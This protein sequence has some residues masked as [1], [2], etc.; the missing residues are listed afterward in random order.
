MF[1]CET[2][3]AAK[4]R[5]CALE[6]N[7]VYRFLSSRY[8]LIAA[9]LLALGLTSFSLQGGWA[10]DDYIHKT[11]I[12]KTSPFADLLGT[13]DGLFDFFDGNPDRTTRLIEA[14]IYPWWTYSK[15]KVSFWRPISEWS[16]YLDY[17][18]WP[19]RPDLMHLQNLFWF[20]LLVCAVGVAY[21]RLTGAG[22]V[23]GLAVLLYAIDDA[24]GTPVGYLANRNVLLAAAFGVFCLVCHDRWVRD[25]RWHQGLLAL[26]LF[27]MSL[28]SAEAGVATCAYLLAYGFFLDPR[29]RWDRLRSLAPYGMVTVV[30]RVIW[31]QLDKGVSGAGLYIDLLADPLEYGLNLLS[32]A[33]V[34]LLGQWFVPPSDLGFTL[35]PGEFMLFVLGA[36]V[37]LGVLAIPI[38]PLVRRTPQTRFWAC[39]MLL[40]LL[41]AVSSLPSDRMLIFVGIGAHALLATFLVG[42]FVTRAPE[43]RHWSLVVLGVL[44]VAVHMLFAP[45]FLGLRS[46]H[47]VGPR[48]VLPQL[49]SYAALDASI[50]DRQ[51]IVVNSKT[52]SDAGFFLLQSALASD[53]LPTRLRSLAP[54]AG[55]L[56]I[57]RPDAFSLSI[58]PENGFYPTVAARFLRPPKYPIR[59]GEQIH[60]TGMTVTVTEWTSDQRPAAATFRF[61]LPLDD[62][63]LHWVRSGTRS[64][65]PFDIPDIGQGY[66]VSPAER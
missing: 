8:A 66:V 50:S 61:D 3:E 19:D 44:L 2:T 64:W 41:P 36:L 42:V 48:H 43:Y 10:A 56:A 30:W 24:R 17:F 14:G 15:I 63:S 34:L 38:I 39:G 5:L 65:E 52:P 7:V 27:G 25:G 23:A 11:V 47:P 6:E 45:A 29:P 62:E 55:Q 60:L 57:H 28:L 40:S 37:L 32:R 51:L 49:Y 18:L 16:H 59:V 12:L 13:D 58:R 20:G 33:P 21:R 53:P 1:S 46:A 35:G 9:V 26:G 54:G 4:C 31:T 22:P